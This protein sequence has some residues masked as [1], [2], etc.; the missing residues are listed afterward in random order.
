MPL[1]L[2]GLVL[3][4]L[5]DCTTAARDNNL[6]KI[7]R[8]VYLSVAAHGA[9]S[10]LMAPLSSAQSVIFRIMSNILWRKNECLVDPTTSC[11]GNPTCVLQ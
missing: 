3:I 6:Q 11:C 2:S 9:A 10:M 7:R 8:V 4:G 1:L 5:A